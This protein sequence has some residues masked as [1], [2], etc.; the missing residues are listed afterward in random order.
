MVAELTCSDYIKQVVGR[1]QAAKTS[2]SRFLHQTSVT[3]VWIT[4]F[5]SQQTEDFP[6]ILFCQFIRECESRLV[7]DYKESYLY[8]HTREMVRQENSSDL[9]NLF[10]LLNGIPKAL[11]PVVQ[12]FEEHIKERGDIHV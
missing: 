2:G 7:V 3:K 12:E 1:L 11:Q 9:S 5:N 10:I 8:A 6:F 4:L